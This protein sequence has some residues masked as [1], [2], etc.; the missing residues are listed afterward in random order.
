MNS[1]ACTLVLMVVVGSD[2]EVEHRGFPIEGVTK[3]KLGE[4]LSRK[5]PIPVVLD[6]AVENEVVLLIG[7]AEH[8]LMDEV[9]ATGF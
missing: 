8:A 7:V 6:A 3:T 2:G 9:G 4:V 5:M 1:C